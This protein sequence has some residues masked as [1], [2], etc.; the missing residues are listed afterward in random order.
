MPPSGS[1]TSQSTRA[2]ATFRDPAGTTY[3]RSLALG[4]STPVEADQVQS[5]GLGISAASHCMNSS[6]LSTKCARSPVIYD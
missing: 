1:S 3:A 5:R 4:A 2:P 6:G